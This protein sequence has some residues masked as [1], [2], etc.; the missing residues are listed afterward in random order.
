MGGALNDDD[1]GL[2]AADVPIL[3]ARLE[4][5]HLPESEAEDMQ[6][7]DYGLVRRC[8]EKLVKAIASVAEAQGFVPGNV[9]SR[10]LSM[11]A[12]QYTTFS[13]PVPG[14][15]GGANEKELKP[16]RGRLD[17]LPRAAAPRGA[18]A[19]GAAVVLAQ[20]AGVCGQRRARAQA[21]RVGAAQHRA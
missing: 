13:V 20:E 8:L 12:A 16:E 18:C 2:V 11:I 17:R 9:L 7:A 3:T 1:D 6:G 15:Q 10:F 14:L 4:N 5:R 21:R 19:G